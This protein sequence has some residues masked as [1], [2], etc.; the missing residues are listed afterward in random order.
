M[1]VKTGEIERWRLQKLQSSVKSRCDDW[2]W[3][4]I[5]QKLR[6][7]TVAFFLQ[8]NL[9]EPIVHLWNFLMLLVI[10]IFLI[11]LIRPSE[12]LAVGEESGA[13]A[14]ERMQC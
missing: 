5:A 11:T 8:K 14:L 10:F 6:K 3:V 9:E 1:L 4:K 12:K 7:K 13:E 2:S